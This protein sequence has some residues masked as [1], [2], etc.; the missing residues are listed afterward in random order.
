MEERKQL[1]QILWYVGWALL[2]LIIATLLLL[3]FNLLPLPARSKGCFIRQY[4]GLYCPS[5]G[6]TRSAIALSQGQLLASF[7]YHPGVPL[8]ILL[9]LL[10]QFSNLLERLS[11]GHLPIGLPFHPWM[12]IFMVGLF[13]INMLIKNIVSIR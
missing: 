11:K 1:T 12:V 2:A 10:F 13:L 6:G 9:L 5:C 3:H 7:L 4:T 8:G